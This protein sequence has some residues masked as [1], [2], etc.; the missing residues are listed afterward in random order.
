MKELDVLKYLIENHPPYTSEVYCVIDKFVD[1]GYFEVSNEN[2]IMGPTYSITDK[3]L[4]RYL[5]L[6]RE[7]NNDQINRTKRDR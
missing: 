2:Y 4:D 1:N 6:L 5:N 7:N 3:G